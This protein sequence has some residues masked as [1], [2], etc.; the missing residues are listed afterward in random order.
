MYATLLRHYWKSLF[1]RTTWTGA[2]LSLGIASYLLGAYIILHCL[3]IGF[4][5]DIIIK[6]IYPDIALMA[7][8]NQNLLLLA[9]ILFCCRF[10]LQTFPRVR[11]RP[12]LHL[13]ISRP[14]L[15]HFFQLL[16]L[17]NFHNIYPLFFAL[18]FW[19]K[20]VLPAYPAG[21]AL[22]WLSGVLLLLA[23]SN[24]LVIG[25]RLLIGHKLLWGG[26][27]AAGLAGVVA[28]DKILAWQYADA[29]SGY[30]FGHLLGREGGLF[31]VA[32]AAPLAGLY[33]GV[34]K[35]L[36]K[37]IFLDDPGRAQSRN[38]DGV[39]RHLAFLARYGPIGHL[40]QLEIKLMWRNK[41]P[42]QVLF[43][44]LVFVL[45]GF[46]Y[47]SP[48]YEGNIAIFMAPF[49]FLLLSGGLVLNYGQ[50][51]FSW[52]SRYFDGTLVR[53]IDFRAMVR[54]KLLFLQAS[55]L[56]LFLLTSPVVAT[57]APDRFALFAAFFLYNFGF[58]T[59]LYL[60]LA[61]LNFKHINLRQ[62]SFA[63]WN[64]TSIHHFIVILP[65]MVLPILVQYLVADALLSALAIGGFGLASALARRL[66]IPLIAR[67]LAGRKYR[68]GAGFR[69]RKG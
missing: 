29:L 17:G 43:M 32:L 56:V 33:A 68:M 1:R 27:A 51:M 64:A 31:L 22:S 60:L 14:G 54:A 47:L 63:N 53:P 35:G 49:G 23:G 13:P 26:A 42:R 5:A 48:A 34:F 57:I 16:T 61:T 15:I 2:N 50:F 65:L 62:S 20:N 18:P 67:S 46:S 52:E 6:K 45:M 44:S 59:A 30:L 21:A 4:F 25:L 37:S 7:V 11:T 36:S 3:A 38:V 58:T 12:Y 28:L 55:C 8:A 19:F 41:R 40:I 69:G 10:F 39:D 24:Y 66:W 9:A